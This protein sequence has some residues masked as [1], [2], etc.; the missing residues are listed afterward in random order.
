MLNIFNKSIEKQ[1]QD[2]GPQY[3]E[4]SFFG[5]KNEQIPGI[6][7]LNQKA[8]TPILTAYIAFAIA[9]SKLNY[10]DSVSF[11]ELF[12]ADGYYAMVASRLGADKSFA[13]DNDRDGHFEK[14][15]KTSELLGLNVDY[16]KETVGNID[17]LEKVDIVA[18]VGGLYHV[19]NPVEILEKSYE[20][21]NKFL[22]VQT[23][24]SLAN[25]DPN[26]FEEP[27]PEWDWGSR[28]NKVSFDNMIK[29]HNYNIVDYHFNELEGNARPEDRGS[30]YYLIKK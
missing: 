1:I 8:K 6:F 3:H 4:L 29:K 27:A 9:K 7:E 13:I 18:N 15:K 10:K 16:I 17:K 19:S 14:G 5:I 11:A 28:F 22:I 25:E 2:L 21:A 24:V 23:V 26:Y 20:M 12:C 30:V